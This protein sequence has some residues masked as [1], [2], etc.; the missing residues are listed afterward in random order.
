MAKENAP[1]NP[2]EKEDP[3]KDPPEK[4]KEEE[5]WTN[6]EKGPG[7]QPPEPSPKKD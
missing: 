4:P 2:L 3:Q 5:W 1:K 7:W 6:E